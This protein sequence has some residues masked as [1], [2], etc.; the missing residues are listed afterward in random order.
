MVSASL[1]KLKTVIE[2]WNRGTYASLG[3]IHANHPTINGGMKFHRFT[4][5]CFNEACTGPMWIMP[6]RSECYVYSA[7]QDGL[8]APQDALEH[9]VLDW[10]NSDSNNSNGQIKLNQWQRIKYYH[11]VYT[12]FNSNAHDAAKLVTMPP[13]KI[14]KWCLLELLAIPHR[15][16]LYIH[17]HLQKKVMEIITLFIMKKSQRFYWIKPKKYLMINQ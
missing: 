12:M 17:T 13:I 5:C 2:I 7:T 3:K 11:K 8:T 10:P 4:W 1:K 16:Q 15:S 14:C 6:C 9:H